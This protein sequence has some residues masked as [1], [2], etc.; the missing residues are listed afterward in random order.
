[1]EKVTSE[2]KK[3]KLNP[4]VKK[5][6]FALLV[7]IFC[8]GLITL[9]YFLETPGKILG[10]SIFSLIAIFTTFEF[11]KSFEIPTWSKFIIPSAAV[12]IMITPFSENFINFI[13]TPNS[14]LTDLAASSKY[15][16][17]LKELIQEQFMFYVAGIP[18]IGFPI[19]FIFVLIPCLFIKDKAKIIPSFFALLIGIILITFSIKFLLYLIILQFS[20]TLVLITS[21]VLTDTFAYFGG[22]LFGHKLFKKKLAPKISPNKTIEGAIVGFV[23]SSAF[24]FLI[25]GLN[26]AH[27]PGG[28]NFGKMNIDPLISLIV[29]P[30]TIPIAAIVGDLLFSFIK[31]KLNIKDFSNLIPSH[32]GVLDRFDSLIL[33]IFTLSFFM[34]FA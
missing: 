4:M 17:I 11:C 19:I 6:L 32:G 22:R 29:V 28:I 15:T 33:V 27:I 7:A 26:Y 8:V 34:S 3:T 21:V 2:S 5:S 23:I 25:F 30:I 1:M 31:R 10:L 12:F 24:L 20:L 18:G 13:N 9:I 16:N 14:E